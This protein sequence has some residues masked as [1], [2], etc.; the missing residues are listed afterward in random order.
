MAK[1]IFW[2]FDVALVYQ[3]IESH[4]MCMAFHPSTDPGMDN[5]RI[6]CF[7][8]WTNILI[9]Y[10]CICNTH[11]YTF[12]YTHTYVYIPMCAIQTYNTSP[13][14]TIHVVL[15]YIPICVHTLKQMYKLACQ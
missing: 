15:L 12:I 10:T 4:A 7:C 14:H 13:Q 1:G 11:M 9:S 6:G 2:L 8:Q 5:I 3:A